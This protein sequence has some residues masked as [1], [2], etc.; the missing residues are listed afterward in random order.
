[1]IRFYVLIGIIALFF[2]CSGER[3][4]SSV[5]QIG[6]LVFE[7]HFDRKELGAD[8][9][10][11]GGGY[12]IISGELRAQGARNKPLWL[13]AKLPRNA[14]VEFT[15]RSMSRAV[16]I[17]AEVFG[18]GKSKAIKASYTATSY[19]VILGGWGNTR[20]IIARMNEHGPDRK[21]REE[22]KGV[23]EKSYRFSIVREK[24]LFSWSL[25]GQPFLEMDDP[26]PLEGPDHEYFAFNNW[27]SEVFFDDVAVYEL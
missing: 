13:K 20:S 15:A 10:D 12:R 21:A 7:D 16:D 19:V 9:L 22:P 11:T 25:D 14:R 26:K 27:T 23:P 6:R 18:D 17:K 2:G 24:N 3:A 5:K 4:G 8:W 1:M